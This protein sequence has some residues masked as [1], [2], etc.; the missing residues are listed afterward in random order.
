MRGVS[1]KDVAEIRIDRLVMNGPSRIHQIPR[2]KKLGKLE[3]KLIGNLRIW[4]PSPTRSFSAHLED[5]SPD[6]VHPSSVHGMTKKWNG[7][8]TTI[9]FVLLATISGLHK[10]KPGPKMRRLYSQTWMNLDTC[11]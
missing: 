6:Q 9:Y 7:L 5:K 2:I 8:Q 11:V 3:E 1:T 4:V 10:R